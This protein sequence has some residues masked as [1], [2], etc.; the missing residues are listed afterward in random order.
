MFHT[1]KTEEDYGD[2]IYLG[3]GFTICFEIDD[4]QT[5]ITIKDSWKYNEIEIREFLNEKFG[6]KCSSLE[7]ERILNEWMWHNYGF[8][9]NLPLIKNKGKDASI[10]LHREDNEHGP[11]SW[12]MNNIKF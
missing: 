5:T 4:N 10:Y 3:D 9:T 6:K 7:L 8:A 12:I 11:L 1:E 2:N